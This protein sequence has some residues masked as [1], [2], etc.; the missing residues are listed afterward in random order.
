MV[1]PANPIHHGFVAAALCVYM[2]VRVRCA[3]Q[4]TAVTASLLQCMIVGPVGV[5]VF[6]MCSFRDGCRGLD[7]AGGSTDCREISRL[8]RFVDPNRRAQ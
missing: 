7:E 6:V 8:P 3:L 5:R 2:V 1:P 4:R